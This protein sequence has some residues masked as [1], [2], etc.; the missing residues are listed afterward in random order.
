[1]MPKDVMSRNRQIANM[2]KNKTNNPLLKG[3]GGI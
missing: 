1:M 2:K 3:E